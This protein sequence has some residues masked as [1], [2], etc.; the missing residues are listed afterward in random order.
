MF[1]EDYCDM[2]GDYIEAGECACSLA[3][4]DVLE[5]LLDDDE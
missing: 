1:N 4:L 5:E 2:C 3:E